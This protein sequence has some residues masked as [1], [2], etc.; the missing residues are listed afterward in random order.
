MDASEAVRHDSIASSSMTSP[1]RNL[2]NGGC[3][4]GPYNRSSNDLSLPP[5]GFP[6]LR[7]PVVVGLNPS[8][9]H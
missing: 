4:E 2:P 7:L 8:I 9:G 1:Q 6:S 3:S 5:G